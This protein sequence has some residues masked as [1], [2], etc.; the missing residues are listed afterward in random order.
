M[1]LIPEGWAI[2]VCPSGT[3]MWPGFAGLVWKQIL[4]ALDLE[5]CATRLGNRPLLRL[6]LQTAT[7]LTGPL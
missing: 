6:L 5:V 3:M 4:A 7:A 2:I 1:R